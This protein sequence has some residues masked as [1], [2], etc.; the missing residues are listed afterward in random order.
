MSGEDRGRV[1]LSRRTLLGSV[2]TL[3]DGRAFLRGSRVETAN[4]GLY[5]RP[6]GLCGSD[7]GATGAPLVDPGDVK[8]GDF[9]VALFRLASCTTPAK[10]WPSGGPSA[11]AENG[12]TDPDEDGGPGATTPALVEL[13]DAVQVA[14]G[15][16]TTTGLAATDPGATLLSDRDPDSAVPQPATQYSLRA[17]PTLA[18]TGEGI[19]LVGDVDAAAGGRPCFAGE[20]DHHVSVVWWLPVNHGNRVQGDSATFDLGFAA[21]QCRHNA[22]ADV[23]VAPDEDL[24]TGIDDATEGDV[25]EVGLGTFAGPVTV[26]TAGP[27]L[28]SVGSR[29]TVA[30]TGATA[31]VTVDAPGVTVE[32]FEVTTPDGLLGVSVASG[33]DDVTVRCNRIRDVGPTGSLGVTGVVVRSGDREGISITDNRIETLRQEAPD[34]VGPAVN[35]I[36][37]AEGSSTDATVTGNTITGLQSDLAPLGVVVQPTVE[38]LRVEDTLVADPVAANRLEPYD[39]TTFARG[40]SVDSPGAVGFDV[41]DDTIRG[42]VSEDGFSGEDSKLEAGVPVTDLTVG[43]NNLLSAVVAETD[44][45]GDPG[46]PVEIQTDGERG[47]RPR[48]GGRERRDENVDVDPFASGSQ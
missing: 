45:W 10:L 19:P 40:L 38:G 8:P 18:G 4:G 37:L 20:T 23:Y 43:G 14:F 15:V 1:D 42:V 32:R 5:D 21:E 39:G 7:A 9:G 11:A 48:R 12:L 46:G 6:D 31:A 17:F 3:G 25:V 44:D 34:G 35:G 41:E 27:T 24:Q 30:A 29:A 22:T 47:A 33:V 26:D 36:L 13:L 16:G 28:R 2:A